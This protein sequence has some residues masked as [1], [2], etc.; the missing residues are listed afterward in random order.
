MEPET[1]IYE[2]DRILDKRIIRKGRG[3]STQYRIHWKGW[4]PEHNQWYS[5]RDLQDCA[6]LIEEY[7]QCMQQWDL[8]GIASLDS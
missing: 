4:G 7:K 3:F 5:V 1:D 8:G 6:E 2:V